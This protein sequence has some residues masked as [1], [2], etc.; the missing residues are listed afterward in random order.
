[1]QMLQTFALGVYEVWVALFARFA[2]SWG[3]EIHLSA[4]AGVC[5]KAVPN[6]RECPRSY[7]DP[8][9]TNELK[10]LVA[11][12]GPLGQAQA[13]GRLVRRL[14]PA[15]STRHKKKPLKRLKMLT[16]EAWGNELATTWTS[17]HTVHWSWCSV[18]ITS[19][20]IAKPAHLGVFTRPI[21]QSQ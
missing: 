7:F 19:S 2:G 12:A 8:A 11:H 16:V 6:L 3:G 9:W 17:S 10:T 13:F 15:A 5:C 18:D 14:S 4:C 1:M 21:L 20:H